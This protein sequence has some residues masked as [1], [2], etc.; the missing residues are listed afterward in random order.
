MESIS[1]FECYSGYKSFLYFY[2]FVDT[3]KR[4]FVDLAAVEGPIILQ[5]IVFG[6][7]VALL[8]ALL[9]LRRRFAVEPA[10]G[11]FVLKLLVGPLAATQVLDCFSF[12]CV[13]ALV[14]SSWV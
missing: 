5:Y 6:S 7:L 11:E 12:Y 14:I 1:V 10:D 3:F 8:H 9:F 2:K 13:K 4:L